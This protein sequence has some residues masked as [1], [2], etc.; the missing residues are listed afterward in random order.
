MDNLLK[1]MFLR[2]RM[3]S[4]GFVSLDF[5][6]GFNRIKHLSTDLELIK[7]VCQ[8][9]NVV[10]YRTGEDGQDRLRRREGWEQWVLNMAD[11]DAVAQNEGPKELR[12][13]PVPRPSG[14]DQ[15]NPPLWPMS[16]VE[17][18]GPYGN[19][20]YPQ[21]N[22]YSHGQDSAP[23]ADSV[24]NGASENSIDAA[25]SSGQPIEASTVSP[26]PDSFPDAHVAT[27]AIIVR[28]P[29]QSLSQTAPSS[30]TLSN[31]SLDSKIHVR[32]TSEDLVMC[33]VKV[34]STD[35]SDK[36]DHPD[37]KIFRYSNTAQEYCQPCC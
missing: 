31:V 15:S 6:A 25:V 26:E 2:R 28:K 35:S 12:Q 17:P 30:R 20:P 13:P 16:A 19:I 34:D 33:S 18:T 24:P 23:A 21:M 8:Q 1:D 3:D 10:Q 4:Q 27:L 22:G 11:R 5:I 14:F 9:S 29:L 32:D 36:Y 7:L 37:D